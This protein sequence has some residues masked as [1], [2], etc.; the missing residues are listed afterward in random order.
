M[1]FLY[2]ESLG[3]LGY[4]DTDG[5]QEPSG[6]GLNNTSYFNNIQTANSYW[7]STEYSFT[8]DT[9]W[10]F[11]F[12]YGS[13]EYDGKIVSNKFAWALRDGDVNVIPAPSAILLGSIG[14]GFVTWLRRRR[15]I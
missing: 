8:S 3:N 13:Q 15:T 1:G 4:L 2:Y 6:W 14:V 11:Q 7:S 9:A 12:Y 5:T 10:V